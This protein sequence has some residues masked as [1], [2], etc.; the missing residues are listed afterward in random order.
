MHLFFIVRFVICS[1]TTV[2]SLT[3]HKAVQLVKSPVNLTRHGMGSSGTDFNGRTC[4]IDS[5][6]EDLPVEKK[7]SQRMERLVMELL[8]NGNESQM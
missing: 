7:V 6:E 1:K 3:K 5:D 2:N 8:R 4:L